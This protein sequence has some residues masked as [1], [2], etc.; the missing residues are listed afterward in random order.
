MK[1]G[2]LSDSHDNLPKIEQAVKFF[3]RQKIGFLL[4]AGDFVAPFAV[5]KLRALKCDWRG[6]FGNNDGEKNGLT[7]ISKGR[8]RKGPLKIRLAGR[9]IIL[10]HDINSIHP[11]EEKA[12]LLVYGHSHKPEVKKLNAKLL[13]NPGEC[14]GWLSGRSSVAIVDLARL[15]AKIF[16]I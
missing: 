9:K 4:H 13:V 7:R 11:K 15:S 1:I 8:I 3:K 6:V 2:I 12:D 5:L 10:A 16:Q 14:G